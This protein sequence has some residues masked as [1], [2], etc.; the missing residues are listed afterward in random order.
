MTIRKLPHL[1][2][3]ALLALECLLR[4]GH[5]PQS[6]TQG[7]IKQTKYV[8]VIG[9]LFKQAQRPVI[10][11][12]ALP[13][14][15]PR[16]LRNPTAILIAAET[17]IRPPESPNRGWAH[18]AIFQLKI[19]HEKGTPVSSI[20]LS[21]LACSPTGPP[22]HL[23]SAIFKP[24]CELY[25]L[26]NEQMEVPEN[27]RQRTVSEGD[28]IPKILACRFCECNAPRSEAVPIISL[29]LSSACSMH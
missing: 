4:N 11:S 3:A 6:A 24:P 2:L 14:P 26:S 10:C 23:L 15:L 27:A 21:P 5:T 1:S 16:T 17:S 18:M 20:L 29:C 12:S 19:L 28:R 7:P 8:D 25:N 13:R 9:L 22:H